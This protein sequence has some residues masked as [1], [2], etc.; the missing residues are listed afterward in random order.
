MAEPSGDADAISPT[1]DFGLSRLTAVTALAILD[2]ID[3][4]KACGV[5]KVSLA[6][7]LRRFPG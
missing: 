5:P 2:L 4:A 7:E 1:D 3:S 6:C